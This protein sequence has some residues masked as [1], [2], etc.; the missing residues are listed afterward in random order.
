MRPCAKR[1]A[2]EWSWVGKL[3]RH[4]GVEIKT[5]EEFVKNS[6]VCVTGVYEKEQEDKSRDLEL[7]V[8]KGCGNAL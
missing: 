6:G 8:P 5:R 3:E 2:G 4:V 7:K 1:V